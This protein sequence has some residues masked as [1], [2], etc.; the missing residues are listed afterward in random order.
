M[1]ALKIDRVSLTPNPVD[2]GT[3]LKISVGVSSDDRLAFVGRY[4][5][6]Y[7]NTPKHIAKPLAHVND[8]VKK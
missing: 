3:Q 6:V 2:A 7:V 8:Y 4:V 1:A 5:G